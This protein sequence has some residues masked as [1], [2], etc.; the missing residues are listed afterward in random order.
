MNASQVQPELASFAWDAL[1]NGRANVHEALDYLREQTGVE[2]VA[3]LKEAVYA[4][5]SDSLSDVPQ[6]TLITF[7][8]DDYARE[9]MKRIRRLI[10]GSMWVLASFAVSDLKRHWAGYVE[11]GQHYEFDVVEQAR[12]IIAWCHRAEIAIKLCRQVEDLPQ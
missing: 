8:T 9:T 12:Q 11:H 3:A 4:A 5:A 10:D 1:A 2:D 7:D 6:L